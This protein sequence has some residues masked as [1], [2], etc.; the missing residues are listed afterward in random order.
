M[1]LKNYKYLKN[2]IIPIH[3][4]LKKNPYDASKAVVKHDDNGMY[5]LK[6][7]KKVYIHSQQN[8][9]FEVEVILDSY[10]D[11]SEKDEIIL[12][13]IGNGEILRQICNLVKGSALIYVIDFMS[14]LQL[15][16]NYQDL[17]YIKLNRIVT[18]TLMDI[19]MNID[20]FYNKFL[21][22]TKGS[23]EIIVWPQYQRL[24]S[25]KVQE[26]INNLS[27]TVISKR[28]LTTAYEAFEKRWTVNALKNFKHVI[29]TP[30]LL[31]IKKYDFS[32]SKAIIVG[33][34]PS[35]N[36][37]IP[38]LKKI[39]AENN[40]YI[41]G[42]GS[43]NKTL[44]KHGIKPDAFLTYDPKE[45]NQLV[46]Q[47]Y[48]DTNLDIPII[49]GSTVGHE[50]IIANDNRFRYHILI[51]QDS[52][53]STLIPS[54]NDGDFVGDSPT[55]AII[56][57]QVLVKLKFGE[58]MFAG[59]NL[60]YHKNARYSDGINYKH[61]SNS[62][63][64]KEKEKSKVIVDVYG[65]DMLTTDSF[66]IMKKLIEKIIS[67]STDIKFTNTTKYGAKIE[68]AQFAD[69]ETYSIGKHLNNKPFDFLD[70]SLKQSYS[71]DEV[72][73]S[74]ER[75][76]QS[77]IELMGYFREIDII[78]K[79][80]AE[81]LNENKIA[82]LDGLDFKLEKSYNDMYGNKYYRTILLPMNR[83]QNNFL[84]SEFRKIKYENDV[85]KKYSL[86]YNQIGSL[87]FSVINDYNQ[88][89]NDF[90]SIKDILSK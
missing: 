54:L 8:E 30:N 2:N 19:T 5:V 55:I 37:D 40:I 48:I 61:L 10:P 28:K 78:L 65:N 47:E 24:Y 62:I 71:I 36:Y 74:Y 87:I 89:Q 64:E 52:I 57:L 33:A 86:I 83:N 68:G 43:A 46:L 69:L 16:L 14:S 82:K 75:L 20:T 27:E 60:G 4:L 11:L 7:N 31:D 72:I 25:E 90:I 79:E 85:R 59:Q 17:E 44:L 34:G 22:N 13:G 38:T 80:I 21:S 26:F 84:L 51:N 15:M 12:F 42:I 1:L 39:A 23:T 29:R 58:I 9:E 73:R 35:L 49:F 53:S 3:N 63:S 50:T 76:D 6:S 67:K 77:R 45:I 70:N 41:F 88:T 81:R 32:S 18:F 56:T 66:M